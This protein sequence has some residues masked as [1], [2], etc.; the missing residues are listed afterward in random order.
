MLT[1]RTILFSASAAT[2]GVVTWILAVERFGEL[3]Q[4][5]VRAVAKRHVT[6]WSAW[7]LLFSAVQV[8]PAVTA[9]SVLAEGSTKS[10]L[11]VLGDKN[12]P[13]YEF[14]VDGKPVGVS[15]DLWREIARALGRPL[16]MRLYQWA[17]SQARVRRGEA[18][19]LSIMSIN[20]ERS[21]LYDFSRPTFTSKFPMF[22]RTEMLDK[23]N[24]YDLSGKR[25]AVKRGGF[26][27]T[28]IETLHPEA[29]MVFVENA[30]EGFRKLLSAEVD[31]V[32]EDELVGYAVLREKNFQGIRAT[33][34]ALSI[35]T[36]HVAVAKGNS[37]LLRQI[38]EALEMVKTSGK[39]DQIADKWARQDTVLI[40]KKT[41]RL[42][43]VS[44]FSVIVV[45]IILAG[46]AYVFRVR[47]T[48]LAL[49]KEIAEHKRTEAA[50]R[51]S[52]ER[53]RL[54]LDSAGEGIYGLNL[55]GKTTFVNPKACELL[56]FKAYELIGRPMHD[57]I[58]HSYP[59]GSV[60]PREKC[61]M[62]AAFT[63][64]KVYSVTNEV[65]W[66]KNGTS[67]FVAY[68]S[69]PIRKNGELV[70]AVV[71]FNDTSELTKVRIEKERT[72]QELI[73]YIDT[74]NAPIFGVDSEGLVN[75][76]NQEAAR[77]TGFSRNEVMGWN[78]VA[79]FI[80][81]DFKAPVKE[82]LNKAL[83]DEGTS[84]FEFP[85]CTKSGKRVDILLNS[86]PR[87]D[88]TGAIVGV[89][90]FGQD[91]TERKRVKEALQ[92]SEERFHS[93]FEN[94]PLGSIIISATS[95]IEDLNSVAV[96]IFG[97]KTQEIVGRNFSLLMAPPDIDNLNAYIQN[98]ADTGDTKII[99]NGH[100][101]TGVR[102][103][104]ES[105][106]MR[107]EI[108]K[109]HLK[110]HPSFICSVTDLT[111]TKGLELQLRQ[112]QKM[113]AVG[114]LTGGVAH[115]F[116][117]LLAIINGNLELLRETGD[118]KD[119]P[120]EML[121]RAIAAVDQGSNLTDQ[122]LTF[123]R[124]QTLNPKTIEIN[125][126]LFDT[127]GLLT[128]TLGEDILIKT[129]FETH[130]PLI[131]VDPGM[132]RNAILNLALN[133][134]DAMPKGGTLTIKTARVD[135]DGKVFYDNQGILTGPHVG[136]SICD[137]GS[138]IKKKDL[139]RVFEPFFTTKGIGE[140][141]GL[142]LSMV[143]GFVKQSG[144]HVSIHSKKGKGTTIDLYFPETDSLDLKTKE[145][146]PRPQ[147]E[148][149]GSETILVV[150]DNE[151]VR[152]VTVAMLSR[153]G[154]EVLESKDGLSALKV[155]GKN[156]NGVDLVFSDVV[157][158]SGMSGIDLSNE[159]K[160]NY[161]DIKVLMTS[162]Y[163]DKVLGNKN[164]GVRLLRKPY[165]KADLAE[166][167]RM[168]LGHPVTRHL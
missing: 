72:A 81:D 99:S 31:G 130:I 46:A 113:E 16:D 52:Q 87:R 112:S 70:G 58:H 144:G 37:A 141:T 27:R 101:V 134:R 73:T 108:G 39:F 13:P 67:F 106:P 33:S 6:W 145:S 139:D 119:E 147:T 161:R 14:L 38:D 8:F 64:G 91:I 162:G 49:R 54:I 12:Y 44:G 15:V 84:N 109:I 154:Y 116:N 47:R 41:I 23:F 118:L 9:P 165:K 135:L 90:G 59:D 102:K 153:M 48:N 149:K 159:L 92:E 55:K 163:P 93:A 65:L 85:L 88:V 30:F 133:A 132:L 117:N 21:K 160:R 103:N 167:V 136:I 2:A 66:R 28:I 166:A 40:K 18:K 74:A 68:T 61:P 43:L 82:V 121:R 129:A 69:T 142:G 20:N 4:A 104:G 78:L 10:P 131:K 115:D 140:G 76:W 123:S 53:N 79:N 75:V 25:I 51:E 97:Y 56:G 98:Y 127:V 89:I 34:V 57:L 150:E 110:N 95:L 155:L 124:Q 5:R 128:R 71:T 11:V 22:V 77:I 26:P 137:T 156:G 36:A 1:L 83:R 151:H 126:L 62:Y 42:V 86:T 148:A 60:Y 107:F 19:V 63:D 146:T 29:V 3:T 94:V 7:G 114:Q 125:T 168:A 164:T 138:G 80:A 50:L 24:V 35:Q 152:M 105:F 17:D 122:L 32:I 100:E 111:K 120:L 45:I 158:P 143:F 157:M 96:E